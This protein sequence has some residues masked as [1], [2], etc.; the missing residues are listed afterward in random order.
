[1]VFL[2]QFLRLRPLTHLAHQRRPSLR[3]V[4][5]VRVLSLVSRRQHFSTGEMRRRKNGADGLDPSVGLYN[6][7]LS[8]ECQMSQKA[9]H[10]SPV[11]L[12]LRLGLIKIGHQ[13]RIDKSALELTGNCKSAQIQRQRGGGRPSLG[14]GLC[15]ANVAVQQIVE[16]VRR[17]ERMAKAQGRNA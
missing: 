9:T 2:I 15:Q 11:G 1:M 13:R 7:Q 8:F 12:H 5:F 6:V 16:E 4:R 17:F 3:C 14:E 10:S